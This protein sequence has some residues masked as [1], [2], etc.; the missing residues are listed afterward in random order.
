MARVRYSLNG[1]GTFTVTDGTSTY[2][3][4]EK[5]GLTEFTKDDYIVELESG[6]DVLDHDHVRWCAHDAACDA[7][8]VV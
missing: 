4:R 3:V 5:P 8:G 7:F 6:P 2:S 1:D